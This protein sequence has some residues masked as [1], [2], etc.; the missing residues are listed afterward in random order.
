MAPPPVEPRTSPIRWIWLL[1][2]LVIIGLLLWWWF[3]GSAAG[4][5]PQSSYGATVNTPPATANPAGSWDSAGMNQA[6]AP[7]S[8]TIANE[9]NT[10]QTGTQEPA[11]NP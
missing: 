4:P 11:T 7:S 2:A 6:V 9:M 1:V 8:A 10:N 3:G 5:A